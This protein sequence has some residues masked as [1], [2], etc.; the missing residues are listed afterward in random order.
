MSAHLLTELTVFVLAVF[1]GFEA[2]SKVPTM[3]HTPLMSATNAIHGIVLVGAIL[4]AGLANP[5]LHPVLGVLLVILA[6]PE[7]LRRLHRD[8]TDAGDVQGQAC[9][10][11]HT[12]RHRRE[13]CVTTE[14]L[15][16]PVDLAYLI[17]GICFI[18]GLHYLSSPKTA[19]LGNRISMAGM[20]IAVIATLTQGIV[21]W[22]RSVS[23]SSSAPRSESTLRASSR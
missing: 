20:A 8:R 22:W 5:T 17:T 11:V 18:L 7:R 23:A 4:V 9:A 15:A 21:G 19:L 16:N 1:V 6:E 14:Q 3:L 12:C 2:I 13:T 10:G